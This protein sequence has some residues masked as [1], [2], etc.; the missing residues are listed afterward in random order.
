MSIAKQVKIFSNFKK[1]STKVSGSRQQIIDIA[2]EYERIGEQKN[3]DINLKLSGE[4]IILKKFDLEEYDNYI[5]NTDYSLNKDTSKFEDFY[6]TTPTIQATNFVN[7]GGINLTFLASK[8]EWTEFYK[9]VS[10]FI[11]NYM[12]EDYRILSEVIQFDEFTPHLQ[13]M[14][15]YRTEIKSSDEKDIRNDKELFEKVASNKFTRYNSSLKG[16]ENYTDPKSKKLYKH[17]KEK[18]IEENREEIIK[19]YKPRNKK[20]DMKYCFTTT[21]TIA[22]KSNS[23]QDYQ[24]KLFNFCKEHKF[25][26][27][28]C[29]KATEIRGEE[30]EFVKNS[31]EKVYDGKSK[32]HYE[33]KETIERENKN[34]E[35]K[36]LK[37]EPLTEIE[38]Y[39]Y[40]RKRN[41]EKLKEEFMELDKEEWRE[42]FNKKIETKFD[43]N[44]KIQHDYIALAKEIEYKEYLKLEEEKLKAQKEK[45]ES[46]IE[47][48]KI[49]EDLKSQ[50]NELQ[51]VKD[52]KENIRGQITKF[53]NT[54][55]WVNIQMLE[56]IYNEKSEHK[57][58]MFDS[59]PMITTTKENY[60][61]IF[62]MAKDNS[63]KLSSFKNSL[64]EKEF[65]IANLKEKYQ[66]LEEIKNSELNSKNEKIKQLESTIRLR[67]NEITNLKQEKKK[68]EK[69]LDEVKGELTWYKRTL[70]VIQNVMKYVPNLKKIVD[71]IID[72]VSNLS[73]YYDENNATKEINVELGFEEPESAWNKIKTQGK[74]LER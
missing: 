42:L 33:I 73:N 58:G 11:K 22:A 60:E 70:N 2:G 65:L 26:K 56:K 19:S 37:R 27:E 39:R 30:V 35:K 24:N 31:T 15:I 14:G 62:R 47:N 10:Q 52:E 18:W 44:A 59:T 63:S 32:D 28:L 7:L 66:R 12:G 23:Y 55:K 9:D 25:I 6:S 68:I 36:I 46:I 41:R 72:K 29:K 64:A 1:K 38:M 50:K 43:F 8:D 4:N 71:K 45:E 3:P 53:T 67:D 17:A 74:T 16:Q 21:K 51:Q 61:Y 13:I 57:K 34:I 40:I 69:E 49:I 54:D 48:K 5:L 20:T